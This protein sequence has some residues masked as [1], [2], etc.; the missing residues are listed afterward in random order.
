MPRMNCRLFLYS[1]LLSLFFFH[2]SEWQLHPSSNSGQKTWCHPLYDFFCI[3]HLN[4]QQ[5]LF[6]LA[7]KYVQNRTLSHCCY[8]SSKRLLLAWIIICSL[9]PPLPFLGSLSDSFKMLVILF[10]CHFS[11]GNSPEDSHLCKIK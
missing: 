7:S 5:V 10:K 9:L 11:P 4:Y 2:H 8:C 3:M 6:S 1:N